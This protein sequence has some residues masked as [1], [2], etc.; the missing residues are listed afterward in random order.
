M[1]KKNQQK[2][3]YYVIEECPVCG[4]KVK[5]EFRDGD[6][7]FKDSGLCP[8]DNSPMYISMIFSEGPQNA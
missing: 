3:V 2:Q 1:M 8:K 4:Y 5:R 6:Y 7:V